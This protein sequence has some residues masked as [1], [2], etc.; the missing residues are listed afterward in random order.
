M[1]MT[2]AQKRYQR[3]ADR[4]LNPPPDF[5]IG[6]KVF[7]RSQFIR[8]TR[9]SKKLADKF[10]GPFEII[11]HP[12]AVSF[13]LRLPDSMRGIH[14]VF[15]ISMLEPQHHNP[16]PGR[17]QPPPP[18]VEVDGEMEFKSRR[19]WTRKWTDIA[20]TDSAISWPG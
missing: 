13:T 11:A 8:T 5:T 1:S 2:E 20:R 6:D 17:D 3:G 15:H 14:P 10:L 19:S 9:P 7:M 4:H 12:G 16:F 18:P